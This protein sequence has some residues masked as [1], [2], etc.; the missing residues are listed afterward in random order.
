[1]CQCR[2]RMCQCR[3]RMC[4]CRTA[5]GAQRESSVSVGIFSFFQQL[6]PQDPA[7]FKLYL[8]AYFSR[9][10][11]TLAHILLY[12]LT[13]IRSIVLFMSHRV[14][15]RIC[16][17][18]L[19]LFENQSDEYL[20]RPMN[21]KIVLAIGVLMTSLAGAA[22]YVAWPDH[23]GSYFLPPIVF[24]SI[25]LTALIVGTLGSDHAVAKLIGS[26]K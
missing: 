13:H 17:P 18:V 8:L 26:R 25:G 1:M 19:R 14:L 4:Q 2:G 20:L 16:W 10:T 22:F 3:G 11:R 23:I 9:F 15:T 24:G 21:R 6:G 12:G 5:A 7:P